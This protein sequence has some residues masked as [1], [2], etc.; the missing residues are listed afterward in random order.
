MC[1]PVPPTATPPGPEF[2][3]E[4]IEVKEKG[5][6]EQD[7]EM[8]SLDPDVELRGLEVRNGE[9]DESGVGGPRLTVLLLWCH[10]I[11]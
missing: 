5:H 10:I 1:S 2:K 9:M 6:V 4:P 3:W 7:Q 11:Y 8:K